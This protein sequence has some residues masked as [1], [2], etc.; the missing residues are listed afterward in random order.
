MLSH[1]TTAS[2]LFGTESI[3]DQIS[4]SIIKL[5]EGDKHK[6][7]KM[8]A[9]LAQ[10]ITAGK[11]LSRHRTHKLDAHAVH[12]MELGGLVEIEK[13]VTAHSSTLREATI[14]LAHFSTFC[15]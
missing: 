7:V 14:F 2:K 6:K 15:K 3:N 10:L 5:A 1:H 13:L 11:S 4:E 12:F 9:S 8:L